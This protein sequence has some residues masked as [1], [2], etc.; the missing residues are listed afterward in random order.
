MQQYK[1]I[2]TAED[3][4]ESHLLPIADAVNSVMLKNISIRNILLIVFEKNISL[5]PFISNVVPY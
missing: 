4:K 2:L 1:N 3:Q 5:L